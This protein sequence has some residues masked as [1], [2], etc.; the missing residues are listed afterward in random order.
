MYDFQTIFL[1]V[2][3]DC[4]SIGILH[5]HRL[6]SNTYSLH[7]ETSCSR[8]STKVGHGSQKYFVKRNISLSG[9]SLY[10]SFTELFFIYS[11]TTRCNRR[12]YSFRGNYTLRLF[13]HLDRCDS[14]FLFFSSFISL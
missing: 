2:I 1:I 11:N 4:I 8:R 9:S 6:S 3:N 13:P 7:I 5:K 10:G 12:Q 14:F